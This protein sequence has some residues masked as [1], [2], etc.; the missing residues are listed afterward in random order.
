MKIA[1]AI[2]AAL[3]VAT[4]AAA[5]YYYREPPPPPRPDYYRPGYPPPRPY[6]RFGQRCDAT[7][8]TPYG[9]EHLI[10][11]IVEPKPLGY[12]CACPAPRR[13]GY[14]PGAYVGGR[15]IR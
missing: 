10:C 12:E 6:G 11:P 9:P 8:R 4:P 7:F 1:L 3:S 2:L 5:Q 14:R 13:S 15:T